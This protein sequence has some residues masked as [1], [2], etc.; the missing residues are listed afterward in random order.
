MKQ[1][2]ILKTGST[3]PDIAAEHGD[4]EQWVMDGLRLPAECVAVVDVSAKQKLPDPTVVGGVVV[5]GAHE[6]VTDG[7]SWLES[8][9]AWLR[10]LVEEGVPILAI[11]YGHQL[12]A[13]V[14]GGEVG[15]HPA[16]R[17]VGTVTVHC[18][19]KAQSDPLFAVLPDIFP[20]QSSHAQSVLSLPPNAVT[21]ASS[22]H[23]PIHAYRI[24]DRAWGVQFHPEF[25]EA[26]MRCYIA[27]Q[28]DEL[29]QQGQD[30]DGIA[31]AVTP[32]P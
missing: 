26:V 21:L 23:E 8:V 31:K 14:L 16:G 2:Y 27:K 7:G 20:A 10:R 1:L 28:R 29:A 30:A 17:E 11:C 13:T 15:Y 25:T 5:T 12:L 18:H 4:F 3:Y 32:S 24:G 19:S 6:M 9:S 22:K